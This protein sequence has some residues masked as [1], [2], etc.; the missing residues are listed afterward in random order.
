MEPATLRLAD[1]RRVSY[2]LFGAADGFPLIAL[3]GTPGSN[4]KF[5]VAAN[6]AAARRLKL[7]AL[8]RWG[9]GLSEAPDRPRLA[10]Y[11]AD[12][13]EIADRLGAARFGVIGISGGGPFAAAV[14]AQ[15]GSRIAASAL[16]APVGPIAG[17]HPRPRLDAVHFASFRVLPHLPLVTTGA[18]Y[19]FGRIAR[20]LPRLATRIATARAPAAD[21]R[22]ADDPEFAHGL[23]QTF[24]AGLAHGSR[25]PTLDLGIFHRRWDVDLAGTLA[26]TRIWIGDQDRN[27]PAAAV[28]SLADQLGRSKAPVTMST[29]AGAGHFWIAHNFAGV[30]DW[31]A[32]HRD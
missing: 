18:S 12:V 9:Y 13:L 11:A 2:R 25:G 24:A 1:G 27:V 7:I 30:C 20:R 28:S 14:A 19:I 22:I 4:L 23:G 6:A 31:I 3:H 15:L 29:I 26:P 16:V 5:R 32:A 8:D 21:K 17:V 10:A